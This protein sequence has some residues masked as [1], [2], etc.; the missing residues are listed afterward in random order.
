VEDLVRRHLAGSEGLEALAKE[1]GGIAELLRQHFA[2][3]YKAH[4]PREMFSAT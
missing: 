1:K 3:A 4:A 2:K